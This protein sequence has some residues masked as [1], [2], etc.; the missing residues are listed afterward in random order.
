VRKLL[1]KMDTAIIETLTKRHNSQQ[2]Y[3]SIR[4]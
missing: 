3:D 2:K 1:N 4:D